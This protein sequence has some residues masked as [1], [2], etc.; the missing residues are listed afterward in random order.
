MDCPAPQVLARMPL[1]EA[2]LLL[3]RW[4][5]DESHLERLFQ[6]FRGRSYEKLISFTVLVHLIS[7]ALLQYRGSARR[8]FERAAEVGELEASLRATYGKLSR[9]PIALSM[10]F[11]AECSDRLRSLYPERAKTKLPKSLRGFHVVVLDGKA[12]KRVA[13]RLKLLRGIPGGLLG[14]RALVALELASGFSVAMHAHPDGDANDVR[15]VP[16]LLPEAGSPA[17]SAALDGRSRV[18]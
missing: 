8:S 7:D 3:W 12:I 14:G 4:I 13:K 11:L 16:E 15:F 1:A 17:R 10:G 6:K 5:A 9:I 2:V 18:L